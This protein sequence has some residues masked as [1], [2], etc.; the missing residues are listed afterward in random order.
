MSK[1]K[2]SEWVYSTAGDESNAAGTEQ[3]DCDERTSFVSWAAR[4]VLHE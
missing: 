2:R 1:W 4:D 3:P